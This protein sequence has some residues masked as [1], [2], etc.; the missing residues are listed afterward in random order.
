M[1]QPTNGPSPSG[2]IQQMVNPQD[3]A[4]LAQQGYLRQQQQLANMGQFA[5]PG[6]GV[7]GIRPTLPGGQIPAQLYHQMGGMTP[8]MQQEFIQRQIQAQQAAIAQQAQAQNGSSGPGKKKRGPKPMVGA[9]MISRQTT[10]LQPPHS[11]EQYIKNAMSVPPP[12]SQIAGHG[13]API[14]NEPIE[15]W[16]DAL[17]E[18]DPRE[19]AMG[20]FR[21]RHEVLGEIFGPDSIKDIPDE[22]YDPWA[23]LGVDGE[24]LE[25]KVLALEKENEE[26]EAQSKIAVEDFRRR[27]REIDAGAEISSST[28]IAA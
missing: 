18:L 23:G 2:N 4:M 20:R 12:Q 3:I 25:A 17:D 16:A 8:Q 6:G 1:F 15:P 22:D 13:T 19:I 9:Q 26:L 28:A 27:L 10:S 21:K 5:A 7:G 24:T 11:Q 14:H